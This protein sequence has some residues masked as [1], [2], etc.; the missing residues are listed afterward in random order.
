MIGNAVPV[1]LA[2]VLA[3]QIMKDLKSVDIVEKKV[4]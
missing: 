1:E 3:R 4:S 2:R